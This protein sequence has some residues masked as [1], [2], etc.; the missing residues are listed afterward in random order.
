MTNPSKARPARMELGALLPPEVAAVV[1][2]RCEAA[3]AALEHVRD[4]FF[5]PA[6]ITEHGLLGVRATG[7]GGALGWDEA[8]ARYVRINRNSTHAFVNQSEPDGQSETFALFAA[9]DAQFSP[10]LA[11]LLAQMVDILGGVR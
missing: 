1:V 8:T 3:V 4:G 7:E 5:V 11:E 2:P 9:H 10:L 6:M